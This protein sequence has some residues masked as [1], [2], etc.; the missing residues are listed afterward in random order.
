MGNFICFVLDLLLTFPHIC[1]REIT[2][3]HLPSL[4]SKS[5]SDH[6][7]VTQKVVTSDTERYN[8]KAMGRTAKS[9]PNADKAFK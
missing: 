3:Q 1:F 8:N 9:R 6:G 7:P 5:L 4:W 2:M